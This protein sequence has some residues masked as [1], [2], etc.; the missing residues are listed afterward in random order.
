MEWLQSNPAVD[1]ERL[2][3]IGWSQGGLVATG[4]AG[5]SGIPDAVALWAA[6]A[7][8][9]TTYGG[10]LGADAL[11]AGAA[12]GDTPLAVTLPGAPKSD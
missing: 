12:T 10:I 7:D 6:V 8:P 9:E 1:G 4:V 3:I 2:A 5:R 11:T